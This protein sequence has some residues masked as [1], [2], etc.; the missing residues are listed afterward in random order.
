MQERFVAGLDAAHFDYSVVDDVPSFDVCSERQRDDWDTYFSGAD[1]EA[2][3][4]EVDTT[5]D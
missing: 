5:T 1:I 3:V 2:M 4:D